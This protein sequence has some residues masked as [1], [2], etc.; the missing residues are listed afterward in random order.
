[1]GAVV[2]ILEDEKKFFALEYI[3]N[4][5]NATQAY[6]A[7]RPG[8]LPHSARTAGWK[9][10]KDPLVKQYIDEWTKERYEQLNITAE[11]ILQE[12][13]EMGFAPKGDE[14][15]TAQVKLKALDLIQK[16]L[17]LQSKNMNVNADVQA[18]VQ[19]VDDL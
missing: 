16:Q 5:R 8:I 19:I 18:Q 2:P 17:G 10:L 11:H 4:G 14:D 12:L 3:S 13:A 6:L 9:L 15:Y 1:M 7:M